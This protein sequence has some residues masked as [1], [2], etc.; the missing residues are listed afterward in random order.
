VNFAFAQPADGAIFQ[1]MKPGSAQT[2][3]W[4]SVL[5]AGCNQFLLKKTLVDHICNPTS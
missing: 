5:T 1:E 2:S 3:V 4:T